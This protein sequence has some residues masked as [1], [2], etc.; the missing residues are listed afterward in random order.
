MRSRH[1]VVITGIVVVLALLFPP[2]ASA[3]SY[4][5]IAST[6]DCYAGL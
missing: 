1:P 5:P 2:A 6:G 4:G 3:A